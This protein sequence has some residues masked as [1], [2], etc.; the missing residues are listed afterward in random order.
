MHIHMNEAHIK[1]VTGD[2]YVSMLVGAHLLA[3]PKIKQHEVYELKALA[4]AHGKYEVEAKYLL[5]RPYAGGHLDSLLI[6]Q[7][8]TDNDGTAASLWRYRSESRGDAGIS[9]LKTLK[10]K[11]PG[12]PAFLEIE[13]SVSREEFDAAVAVAT[14]RVNKIRRYIKH[15]DNDGITVCVDSMKMTDNTLEFAEVEF[16][17]D[18]I[19][20]GR[21]AV[22]GY[23]LPVDLAPIAIRVDGTDL[24]SARR[25]AEKLC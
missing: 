15:Q 2:E 5:T 10:I 3:Y 6:S 16:V 17:S 9:R 11:V 24:F 7:F 4:L 13:L 21:V 20:D 18:D 23:V 12:E 8:Y 1:K 19:E 22:D 14:H 25:L